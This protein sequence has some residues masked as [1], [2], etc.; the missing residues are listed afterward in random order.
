MKTTHFL[1][2]VVGIPAFAWL[3]Y[4]TDWKVAAA[5]FLVLFANNLSQDK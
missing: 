1:G 4:L 2:M 5:I 3:W